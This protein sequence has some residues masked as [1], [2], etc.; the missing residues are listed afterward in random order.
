MEFC[1]WKK[2]AVVAC[3]KGDGTGLFGEWEWQH[4]GATQRGGA[5]STT[6]ACWR[7][8]WEGFRKGSEGG[9]IID[10]SFNHIIEDGVVGRGEGVF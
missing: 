7:V 10:V 5:K 4:G 8:L 9:R 3:L 6:Q 1:F 2:P